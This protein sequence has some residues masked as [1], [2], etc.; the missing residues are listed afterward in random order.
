MINKLCR[1]A[2]WMGVVL[3]L[4][5]VV[6][7]EPAETLPFVPEEASMEVLL[8]YARRFGSTKEKRVARRA[9]RAELFNR[10]TN[11]LSFLMTRAPIKN[12]GLQMLIFEL[13]WQ[14]LPGEEAGPVLFNFVQAPDVATRK[15]AI[16]LLG[17][18]DLA[19]YAPQ[20]VF[21]LDHEKTAGAT[22]RTLGKWGYDAAVPRI[23][24]FVD[25]TN[26]RR[27]ILAVNALG[28]IGDPVS[29][30]V[31]IDATGDPM[32]TVR[33]AAARALVRYGKIAE[34]PVL[35][36]L[37]DADRTSQRE[38]IGVL[39]ELGGRRSLR[40]LRKLNPDDPMS[41]GDIGRAIQAIEKR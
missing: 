29:I 25:D 15:T 41:R 12:N 39:G 26:E 38:L 24:E 8:D 14:K 19:A 5:P 13:A 30:P 34:R 9:A 20:I 17:G 16:F 4:A 27:R 36:V 21:G 7:S 2:V 18:T 37:R 28:D 33:K 31:L 11:A 32:F 22:M 35:A 6:R 1:P 10:G 40:A 23:T 3:M